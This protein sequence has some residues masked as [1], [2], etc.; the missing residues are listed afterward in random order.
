MATKRSVVVTGVSTGIGW[1]ITQVL[2]E[3]GYHVFGSV[4][5]QADAD[6]LQAEFGAEFTPL[7]MDVTDRSA[8]ER[9]ASEVGA[10]LGMATLAGLIDNAGVAVP[11]PLLHLPLDDLRR[12]LEINLVGPLSVTQAFAPLLG[13]DR[14]RTGEPGRI[15]QISSV[16]GKMGTPFLGAYVASKHALEGLSETLRRELMLYGIDV[17]VIAPGAVVTAIGTKGEAEDLSAFLATEYGPALKGFRDYFMEVL[18]KGLPARR[19][20]EF[21]YQVLTAKNPKT[22]YAIVPQRFTNWTLPRLMPARVLD[23]LMAKQLGFRK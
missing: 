7:L 20:G 10:A 23:R 6:K 12:Q 9:C 15:I 18:K 19:L 1:S 16:A 5:R 13:A 22:R 11:G 17:I 21:T 3:K 8:V 2:I 4:R 14:A